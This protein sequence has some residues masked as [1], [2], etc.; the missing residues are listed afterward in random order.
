MKRIISIML[1]FIIAISVFTVI[2]L[3]AG[4]IEKIPESALET[5]A[6]FNVSQ[7]A[8]KSDETAVQTQYEETESVIDEEVPSVEEIETEERLLSEYSYNGFTYTLSN[9]KA[10]ITGYN[11]K[12]VQYLIIPEN[13]NGYTVTAIGY[14]AFMDYTSLNYIRFPSTV[15]MIGSYAFAGC[16]MFKKIALPSCITTIGSYAFGYKGTTANSGKIGGVYIYGVKNSAAYN[17]ANEYSISYRELDTRYVAPVLSPVVIS[18]KTLKVSWE[19]PSGSYMFRVYR[20]LSTDSSWKNIA[21]VKSNY[22]KDENVVSGKTYVYTV[23][24]I[25]YNG[26][27]MSGYDKTGVRLMYVDVV[28][29]NDLS[30]GNNKITVSWNSVGGAKKYRVSYKRSTWDYWKKLTDTTSLS[31]TD[32]NFTNNIT[33]RYMVLPLDSNSNVLNESFETKSVIYHTTPTNLKASA[34]NEQGKIKIS[35]DKVDGCKRYQVF[36]RRSTQ[37]SFKK[38][39]GIA[40][41]NSYVDTGCSSDV[42]YYYTVRCVDSQGNYQSGYESGA[43]IHYFKIP[44]NIKGEKYDE[45]GRIKISWNKTGGAPKYQVFYKRDGWTSWKKC[46]GLTS[47]TSYIDTGCSSGITYYYTVR[48]CD[49]N[50]NFISSYLTNGT[51]IKYKSVQQEVLSKCDKTFIYSIGV[52]FWSTR[53]NIN[54]DGTFYGQYS[55]MDMGVSTVYV[56]TFKG[57]FKNFKQ[58][59]SYTY[60]MELD[61]LKYNKKP[62]TYKYVN[63]LHHYYTGAMGLEGSKSGKRT[64]Y[65]YTPDTPCSVLPDSYVSC[66][67]GMKKTGYLNTYGFYNVTDKAGFKMY[68]SKITD[69]KDEMGP[70]R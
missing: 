5:E 48:A 31:Y 6:G 35:W 29:M 21:E 43:K 2:P 34:I 53:L 36:Y 22:Y 4:A 24:C 51:K 11:D 40:T 17:Y 56:C 42:I 28:P 57:K 38:C 49:S 10:T 70:L 58:V 67:P 19:R 55:D 61:Y 15:T 62:G 60:S 45:E 27:L 44:D 16:T 14:K 20:K 30:V 46:K 47:G 68:D 50:G 25:T 33:Y 64:Y 26:D 23:R 8:E 52:G 54:K 13:V 39:K 63:G 7:D 59:N 9:S 37:S 32:K 1:A 69:F 41:T 65:L 3:S 18:G 66:I 12:T